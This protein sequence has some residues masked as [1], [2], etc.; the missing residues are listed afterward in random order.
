MFDSFIK[1]FLLKNVDV[2]DYVVGE[3]DMRLSIY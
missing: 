2:E 1:S 3:R